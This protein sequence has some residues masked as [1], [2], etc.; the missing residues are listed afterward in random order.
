MSESSLFISNS[1]FDRGTRYFAY[2]SSRPHGEW[3]QRLL[4][5]PGVGHRSGKMFS[6]A[7]GRAALFDQEGCAVRRRNAAIIDSETRDA[8]AR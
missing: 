8:S 3:A 5:V 2:L 4:E 7:C 1:R 6:S